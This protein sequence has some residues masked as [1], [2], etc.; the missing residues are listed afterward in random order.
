M[1]SEKQK[2]KKTKRERCSFEGC[3]KK[4][5][6]TDIKCKCEKRYCQKHRLPETH[7]CS[8]NFKTEGLEQLKN[9]LVKTESSL[10][11]QLRI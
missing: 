10:D 1:K 8:F 6:L 4:L 3:S 2:D 7:H 9:E 5:L 11:K